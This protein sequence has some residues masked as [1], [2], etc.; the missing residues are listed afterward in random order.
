[1]A[2]VLAFSGSAFAQN[3][4]VNASAEV[5][6]SIST[7]SKTDVSF[8]QIDPDLTPTPTLDPDDPANNQGVSGSFQ[9]GNFLVTHANKTVTITFSDITLEETSDGTTPVASD[10]DILDYAL[11]VAVENGDATTASGSPTAANTT[12][13]NSGD[14]INTDASTS[15]TIWVGGDLS[16]NTDAASNGLDAATYYGTVSFTFDYTL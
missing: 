5:I 15:H 8:G 4:N 14:N 13:V 16:L 9:M 11:S 6:A 7:S 10:K 1:L 12:L 3:Q 2:F